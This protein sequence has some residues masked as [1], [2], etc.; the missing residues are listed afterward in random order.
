[1]RSI[2]LTLTA[3]GF[4]VLLCAPAPGARPAKVPAADSLSGENLLSDYERGVLSR[5]MRGLMRDVMAARREVLARPEVAAAREAYEKTAS[6]LGADK[7]KTAAAL[8]AYRELYESGMAS[9]P[10]ITEKIARMKEVGRMLEWDKARVRQKN[11]GLPADTV[12]AMRPEVSISAPVYGKKKA[13]DAQ[14]AAE[15]EPQGQTNSTVSIVV[16]KSRYVTV[17]GKAAGRVAD[18][19]A[20]FR[21]LYGENAKASVIV[22]GEPGVPVSLM[23]KIVE[24]ARGSGFESVQIARDGK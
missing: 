12:A 20:L 8:A 14:P 17:N 7:E 11:A 3:L 2:S 1:M 19:P 16:D 4:A 10:D 9:I 21:S 18:L 23:S 22:D 15:P 13:A 5:E 24:M 6:S